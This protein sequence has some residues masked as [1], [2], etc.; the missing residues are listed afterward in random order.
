M[1]EDSIKIWH[2]NRSVTYLVQMLYDFDL[3]KP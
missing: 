1:S 2:Y 3:N